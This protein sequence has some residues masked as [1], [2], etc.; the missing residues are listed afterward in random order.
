M[1][2]VKVSWLWIKDKTWEHASVYFPC[3][4]TSLKSAPF[5]CL[6]PLPAVAGSLSPVVD[7]TGSSEDTISSWRSPALTF[8]VRESEEF[9][10]MNRESAF[11]YSRMIREW[12]QEKKKSLGYLEN[13]WF[14]TKLVSGVRNKSNRNLNVLTSDAT[15]GSS[16]RGRLAC[17]SAARSAWLCWPDILILVKLSGSELSWV[18]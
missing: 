17:A 7:S 1:N 12:M 5:C 8:T 2:T 3:F 9:H 18:E 13:T 10:Y 16:G 14:E 11:S 15:G 4:P 6:T